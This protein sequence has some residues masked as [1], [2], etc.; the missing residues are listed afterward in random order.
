MIMGHEV[1]IVF[2]RVFCPYFYMPAC[3]PARSAHAVRCV[4]FGTQNQLSGH[5]PAFGGSPAHRRSGSGAVVGSKVM[6]ERPITAET[7]LGIGGD[8]GNGRRAGGDRRQVMRLPSPAAARGGRRRSLGNGSPFIFGN[9]R[10]RKETLG[11]SSI[12]PAA[13]RSFRSDAALDALRR[14]AVHAA[15]P[16]LEG[17]DGRG[18]E[19]GVEGSVSAP[20]SAG[21]ANGFSLV[22]YN[23]PSF[24]ATLAAF[25]ARRYHSL[26]RL[27]T[28]VLPFSSVEPLRYRHPPQSPAWR[29]PL[30]TYLCK[31]QTHS[32]PLFGK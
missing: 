27:P 14:A 5:S 2:C 29:I 9:F 3:E 21:D 23:Y 8:Q 19:A 15:S 11:Q 16:P 31:C 17:G 24:S 4:L 30:P 32:C 10:G 25:F 20:D 18:G 12:W 7:R 26:R 13:T 6:L 28:L 22:L 1:P